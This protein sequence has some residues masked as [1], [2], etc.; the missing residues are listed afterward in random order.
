MSEHR[1]DIQ[2]LEITFATDAGD[3]PAVT[4]VSMYLEEGEILALLGPNCN[5]YIDPD[6][7]VRLSGAPPL[8]IRGGSI[9]VVSHT[10][11]VSGSPSIW[12]LKVAGALTGGGTIKVNGGHLLLNANVAPNLDDFSGIVPCGIR[13]YGVTSLAALGVSASMAEADAALKAAF[14]EVFGPLKAVRTTAPS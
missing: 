10:G 12:A 5:G 8:P 13:G 4:G 6:R 7:G 9:G 2:D 3:V 1:L 11:A 14:A